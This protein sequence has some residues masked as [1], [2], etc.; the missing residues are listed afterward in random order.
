[1]KEEKRKI[2]Q[3]SRNIIKPSLIINCIHKDKS[4]SFCKISEIN[5]QCLNI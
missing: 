5:P 3:Y 4:K 2:E 1:M